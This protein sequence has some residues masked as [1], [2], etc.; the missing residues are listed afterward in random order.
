MGQY[1]TQKIGASGEL[2]VGPPLRANKLD[3]LAELHVLN[4]II[5]TKIIIQWK[6]CNLKVS[7]NRQYFCSRIVLRRIQQY[8]TSLLRNTKNL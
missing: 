3:A 2:R 6:L 4:T 1:G 7:L 5:S 8:G